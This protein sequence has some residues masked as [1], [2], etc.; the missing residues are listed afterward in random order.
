MVIATLAAREACSVLRIRRPKL[1]DLIKSG[2][3]PASFRACRWI[4]LLPN[5]EKHLD[6]M[7]VAA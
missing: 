6:G 2:Q 5:V 3:L 1:Y 7:Q 4:I